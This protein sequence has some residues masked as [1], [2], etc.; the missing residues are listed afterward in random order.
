VEWEVRS[1]AF[2]ILGCVWQ[3][4]G[5]AGAA[6][7]LTATRTHDIVNA[8]TSA[9]VLTFADHGYRGAGERRR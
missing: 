2:V 5:S 3:I 9:E 6:H 8:L 4:T 1:T 7:D